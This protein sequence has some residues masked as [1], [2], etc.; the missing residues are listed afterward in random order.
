MSMRR[1]FI[2]AALCTCATTARAQ[3]T[4]LPSMGWGVSATVAAWHFATPFPQSGG[5]LADVAEVALPFRLK[6]ALGSWSVDL[7][8]AGAF[9]ALHLTSNSTQG[10]N[11]GDDD[12]LVT[13]AGPTDLKLRLSGPLFSDALLLTAGV[14]LPTGKVGLSSDETTVLQVLGAPALGMPI[15][16]FGT[17]AGATLGLVRAFHGDDWAIAIGASGEQRTEYSPIALALTSGRSETKVTPGV[18]GHVTL[19]LDRTIGEGRLSM[20]LVGDMFSKDKV[21]VGAA[22]TDSTSDYTLG[23]Q[24]SAITRIDF[25]AEHWRESGISLAAR[26]RT[27][28]TDATGTTVT[29]SAGTYLEGALGGVLG[30]T[31]GAGLVIG[32]DARWHSGLSFTDAMIGAAATSVGAS[33]GFERAGSSSL[34]RFVVRGQYATFDTGAAKSSGLGVSIGLTVAARRDAR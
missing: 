22:A 31:E 3:E 23:P 6:G 27:E 34:T 24:L 30:G 10:A 5:A 1:L 2:A 15:G 12:R 11:N 32:A 18:A 28:F 29:G 20:V 21:R 4:L 16:A 33:L 17:G 26:R 7:S 14:N 8:G 19:G 13:I 25:G 9:G